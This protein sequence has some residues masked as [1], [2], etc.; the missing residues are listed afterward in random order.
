M[1][2]ATRQATKC[3]PGGFRLRAHIGDT[4]CVLLN[5]QVHI[6]LKH[7]PGVSKQAS[8]IFSIRVL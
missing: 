1:N 5:L 8:E 3:F 7:V 6:Q 4:V 2:L